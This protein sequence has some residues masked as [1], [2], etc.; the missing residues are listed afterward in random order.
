MSIG[1]PHGQYYEAECINC[2]YGEVAVTC[3]HDCCF[4]CVNCE[5]T[6]DVRHDP[7]TYDITLRC[8]MSYAY[9]AQSCKHYMR[10]D[11]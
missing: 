10:S 4:K 7:D 3:D 6:L 11:E 2:P 1:Y 5:L 9:P 8:C